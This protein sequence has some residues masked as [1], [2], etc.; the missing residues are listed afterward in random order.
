MFYYHI[1]II[2]NEFH[3]DILYMLIMYF[4]HI[5]PDYLSCAPPTLTD[6]IPLAS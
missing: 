2:H 4:A 1:L 5:H 3:Y 6:S